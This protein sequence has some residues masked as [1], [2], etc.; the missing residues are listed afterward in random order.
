M[1]ELSKIFIESYEKFLC[2]FRVVKREPMPTIFI[3]IL[4]LILM[5]LFHE[6]LRGLFKQILSSDDLLD[7]NYY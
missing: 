2:K 3:C 5:G 6:F 1:I 4:S 7:N